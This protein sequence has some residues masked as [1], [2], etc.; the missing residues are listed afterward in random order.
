MA[1]FAEGAPCWAV[2]MLPDVAAG[3]RFYGE[4]LGWS[5][6]EPD[7]EREAYTT[8]TL[9]GKAVAG[10]VAKPD[11]RMPTDWNVH[12]STP[13]IS[14]AAGRV[15]EAGGQVIMEPFPLGGA[16]YTAVAADPGGAVFQLW[17]PG[18][19]TGFEAPGEPGAY[20]WAEVYTRAADKEAVDAFYAAVFGFETGDLSETLGEDFVMWAPRGEPADPDHAV[21]GRALIA[22]DAPEH[23]PAHFLLYFAV[24]D[25]DEAVRTT[26]RLGGRT[27]REPAT[28]PFGRYAVLV[29]DQGA[30]F[31]VIAPE[32]G[33]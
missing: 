6:G 17:Q 16:G 10:L 29:D 13:D 5:F 12:L 22:A 1:G 26:N 21:G 32:E 19:M 7:R 28:T 3:R 33:H 18:T 31:A 23:L 15:R 2:A 20:A 4:L 9:G 14:A 25:C 11:G 24:G 30:Y 27:V 8:A